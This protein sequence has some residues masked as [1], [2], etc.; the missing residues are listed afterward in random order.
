MDTHN[1]TVADVASFLD[2]STARVRQLDSRLNPIRVGK[3]KMRLYR[4]SVVEKY[5]ETRTQR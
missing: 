5:A 4:Q 3:I 2:L 1:M